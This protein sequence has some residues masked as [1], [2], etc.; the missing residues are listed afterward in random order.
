[1]KWYLLISTFSCVDNVMFQHIASASTA[2]VVSEI[3]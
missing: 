1:M 2:V 3:R